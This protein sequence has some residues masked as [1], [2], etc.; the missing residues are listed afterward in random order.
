MFTKKSKTEL[1]GLEKA[2]DELLH[3]MHSVNGDSE[4]YAK[5]VKQLGALYTIRDQNGPKR[6]SPDTIAIV[7]GN[8]AGIALI[9]GHERAGIVTSKALSFVMKLR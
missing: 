6:V 4:E 5:M 9:V 7:A 3:E 8:L 2:I 1:P